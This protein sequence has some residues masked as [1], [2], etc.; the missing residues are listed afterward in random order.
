M[1]T[2]EIRVQPPPRYAGLEALR[3][4]QALAVAIAEVVGVKPPMVA[5]G[6]ARHDRRVAGWYAP[7]SRVITLAR[8]DPDEVA[9]IVV[10]EFQHYLDDLRGMHAGGR[11]VHS[12]AF[13]ARLEDLEGFLADELGLVI[14]RRAWCGT[15]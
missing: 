13:Q 8:D 2:P 3:A 9:A 4:A 5:A 1:T 15:T 10:H 12:T 11:V 7:S 14:R 6:Q